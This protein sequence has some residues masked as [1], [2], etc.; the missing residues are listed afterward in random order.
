[1]SKD[2][3]DGG[4]MLSSSQT[5]ATNKPNP[6]FS[7]ADVLAVTQ[8]T[9]SALQGVVYYHTCAN[10][11]PCSGMRRGPKVLN[12]SAYVPTIYSK[13]NVDVDSVVV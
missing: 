7:Q 12:I 1:L 5:V 8:P 6:T 4:D 3:A 2:D 11:C 13:V 10:L 9:V